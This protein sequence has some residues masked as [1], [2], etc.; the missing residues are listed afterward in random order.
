MS[1]EVTLPDDSRRSFAGP[2]LV[3]DVVADIGPGLARA[4]VAARLDGELVDLCEPVE[5]DCRLEVVTVSDAD[6]LDVVRHSCAHLLGHAVKQLYPGAMVS[7]GPVIEN[8]F[9]YDIDYEPGFGNEDMERIEQ[10]MRQLA[11]SAYEVRR[12]I[13]TRERAR[14]VF[15]ER[16]EPYKLE[17][18]DGIPD[19]ERIALYHHQEY[20]DMCRGPHVPHVGHLRHFGLERLAGAYWRGDSANRML[21][22]VYGTAWASASELEQYRERLREAERRDHRKLG[23][24]MELFHFQDEAPGMVF[25]HPAGWQLFRTLRDGI[26]KVVSDNGYREVQTPQLLDRSLW[27]R[28]GHW[29]KFGEMI[30]TVESG[31]REYAIKPMN[32]PAH[33]QIY[34][35]E[36][37]SYRDLPLR[38]AEFG[39]VYRNEPSGTLH[40]LLRARK[41]TQ[42]DAHIFCTAE[43]LPVE[44]RQ[45]V[46]LT[47]QVYRGFGF[48]QVD[49]FL[50]TRPE[51]RVGS[52]LQWDHA[53][54]SLRSVLDDLGWDWSLNPGEG[55]FYGPKIE[56]VLRDSIG[57]VWQ[58]GTA[59][60]DF[61]M[62][63]RLGASYIGE[64]SGKHVPVMVHRAILG[65]LERF[66]GI[67]IEHHAGMLPYWLAP[68]Q[69][70]VL[71]LTEKEQGKAADIAKELAAAGVRVVPD[72]RNEKIGLKIREHSVRRVPYQLVVGAREVEQ[73]KVAVRCRS[74]GDL[75]SMALA[76][77]LGM[78]R[79]RPDATLVY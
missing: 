26:R 71:A 39:E 54:D 16:G 15:E 37:R 9:Y 65:S 4:A 67:L 11:D 69:V 63:E 1:V 27:E 58:C 22:R 18:V 73:G 70:A 50:S 60:V 7:I 34:N 53:E 33:V 31:K 49:I 38:L 25:W 68:V 28:S 42:D 41:F 6:G 32:C 78:S 40:G 44:I 62:P 29:D 12:E 52:D 30:F 76:D 20:I 23:Q 21:Q 48:D 59:Q 66:I 10:R 14:Q 2:V 35:H 56:F 45:F 72:L 74:E 17:I 77:F 55:A 79:Q 8:G 24:R 51:Q 47:M 13:V 43:Q 75:G 64:D 57:R 19:G 61:S 5:G 36:L 46:E 3:S